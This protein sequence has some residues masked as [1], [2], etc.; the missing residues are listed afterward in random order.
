MRRAIR[1]A[2]RTAHPLAGRL[3]VRGAFTLVPELASLA[4]DAFEGL[5]Q[6][7]LREALADLVFG[8][9]RIELFCARIRLKRG[10]LFVQCAHHAA[11]QR[12]AEAREIDRGHEDV[13]EG[14]CAEALVEREPRIDRAGHGERCGAA[15]CGN[16]VQPGAFI[17]TAGRKRRGSA[18]S[19]VR[20][21][22][23]R[24]RVMVQEERVAADAGHV[25]IDDAQCCR[26]RHARVRRRAAGAQDRDARLRRERVGRGDHAADAARARPRA[27]RLA[28]AVHAPG[29]MMLEA[30]D[31]AAASSSS[32][33]GATRRNSSMP[34]MRCERTKCEVASAHRLR[35][36]FRLSRAELRRPSDAHRRVDRRQRA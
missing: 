27:V 17:E 15:L 29:T 31:P 23:A 16:R 6:R 8:F 12:R 36:L 24:R 25:R 19:V 9:R 20:V 30:R 13:L 32:A 34:M 4:G 1:R 11:R 14:Q 26:H 7:R 2:Q 3:D 21:H 5:R 35:D 33:T 22:V 10:M 18:R 28:R